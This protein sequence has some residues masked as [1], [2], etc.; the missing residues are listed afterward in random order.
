MASSARRVH[1]ERLAILVKYQRMSPLV[2]S[3]LYR[4]QGLFGSQE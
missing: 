4:S 2:L 3:L 1:W